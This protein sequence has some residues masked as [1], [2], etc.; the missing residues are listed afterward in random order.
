MFRL[1]PDRPTTWRGSQKLL[2]ERVNDWFVALGHDLGL[3]PQW[4]PIVARGLLAILMIVLAVAAWL[5]ARIILHRGLARFVRRSRST[6]DDAVYDRGVLTRLTRL[7]PAVVVYLFGPLLA[8]ELPWFAE[9]VRRAV[10][11][12]MIGVSVLVLDSVLEATND[13]YNSFVAS[14]RRPIKGY[15]QLIK[16]LA[17]I[18]GF[19][20]MVTTILGTSPAGI[21]GGIGAMSA[22]LLLVFRDSILGLVAGFQIGANDM[23]H[24][25]DWI[26]IPKY[27]ADGDVVDISLQTIKVQNWDKT[28]VSIP[29]YAL[30]SDSFKNWRGMTESGGRRIKRA[31]HI[32]MRSVR[33]LTAEDIK[34]FQR[35]SRIRAYLD[36]KVAEIDAY[37]REHAIDTADS[38][39]G[40]RLTNLGT[41]RAY[42]AAYLRS[43]PKIHNDMTFLVRHLA[44]GPTG[45]PIEIYVFSSDQAWGNYEGI[46]ADIFDHLLA[47]L[48][49]FDL[50]VFQE[51]SGWDL[52]SAARRIRGE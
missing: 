40:R 21:L 18:V 14:K 48:P 49:E 31:V 43:H 52:D 8:P 27:G 7:A 2:I 25:G 12:Y 36:Q 38:V 20:L 51:P 3:G 37:N 42:V 17:Y 23:V 44:P 33:F 30:V 13:I 46:Q 35:F 29:V 11:A 19:I 6:W 41:F 45:I 47:V 10:I 5:T 4:E 16:I 34:H 39:S 26:E 9:L 1:P 50:R 28:I 32:D 15:L 22:V 24:L